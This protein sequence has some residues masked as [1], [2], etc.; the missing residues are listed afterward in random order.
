MK[1]QNYYISRD[2]ANIDANRPHMEYFKFKSDFFMVW[3]QPYRKTTGV[4]TIAV[5]F[6]TI[7]FFYDQ[8]PQFDPKYFKIDGLGHGDLN[9]CMWYS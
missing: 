1:C 7:K 3:V 8:I 5:I 6:Y 2:I 4:H 9:A